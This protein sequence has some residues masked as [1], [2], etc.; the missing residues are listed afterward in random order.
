MAHGYLLDSRCKVG[1]VKSCV[2]SVIAR[3]SMI[4]FGIGRFRKVWSRQSSVECGIAWKDR[5]A[6]GY[7]LDRFV[8]AV[9]GEE[10]LGAA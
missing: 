9:F 4:L 8:S 1:F 2:R 6:N 3:E 7:Y 10:V 5:V